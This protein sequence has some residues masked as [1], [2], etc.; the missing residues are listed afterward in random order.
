MS[1]DCYDEAS[2]VFFSN[3]MTGVG[4][5]ASHV[6]RSYAYIF[7]LKNMKSFGFAAT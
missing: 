6:N 1:F 7:V 5:W 3:L 4:Y 2:V